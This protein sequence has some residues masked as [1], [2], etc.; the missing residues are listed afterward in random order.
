MPFFFAFWNMLSVS[1]EM[2]QAP[3]MLWIR[4]LSQHDPYYILPILMAGTMYL[5]QRMMPTT[6]DPAQ[7]KI[8]MIMPLM[9]TFFFLWA[10]S[11]LVLY[12]LTS[13]VVGIGQQAFINKYWTAETTT[14]DRS[15]RKGPRPGNHA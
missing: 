8:M 1:I 5:M 11:G 2:R 13:N 6:M 9:F 10:Q 7:A 14:K 4:D 3:W 12:W 15:V